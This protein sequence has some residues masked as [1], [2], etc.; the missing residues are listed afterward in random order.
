MQSHAA[1]QPCSHAGVIDI[2]STVLSRYLIQLYKYLS[3]SQQVG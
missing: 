2:F 3:G 1:M